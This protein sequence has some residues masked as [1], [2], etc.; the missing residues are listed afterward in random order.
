MTTPEQVVETFKKMA[1]VVD[2][3]NAGDAAYGNMAPH[4]E[5]SIEFQAALDLVFKGR[6]EP[7]GYTENILHGRRRELKA[8]QASAR[9]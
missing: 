9:N 3:Q 6:D 4:F 2:G 8:R 7:N 1:R 5:E